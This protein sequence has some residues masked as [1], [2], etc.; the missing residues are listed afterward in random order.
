MLLPSHSPQMARACFPAVI[1]KEDS[2]IRLSRTRLSSAQQSGPECR[3]HRGRESTCHLQLGHRKALGCGDG[4]AP[5]WLERHHRE[6]R[7]D[8][9]LAVCSD[10]RLARGQLSCR[11]RR[12][13]STP[14]VLTAVDVEGTNP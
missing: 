7:E 9:T 8:W 6:L 11:L 4:Q 5:R 14:E 10:S 13:S 3:L 1:V 12:T 2:T